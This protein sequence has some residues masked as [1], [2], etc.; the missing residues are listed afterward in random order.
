MDRTKGEEDWEEGGL[1]AGLSLEEEGRGEVREEGE[2]ER[3]ASVAVE[4]D[5]E[6]TSEWE[7]RSVGVELYPGLS[8]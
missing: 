6:G 3:W 1:V 4:R 5:E 8:M 2:V 7:E